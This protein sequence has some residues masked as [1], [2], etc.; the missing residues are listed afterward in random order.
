MNTAAQLDHTFAALADPTR[1]AILARLALGEATVNELARPF[2][3]SQPAIS[4][5]LKVLEAAGLIEAGQDAQRRPRRLVARPLAEVSEWLEP[6]R[7]SWEESFARLDSL[8]EEM[9]G[10]TADPLRQAQGGLSASLG[11]GRD[12]SKKGSPGRKGAAKRGE[13]TP[14]P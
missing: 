2:A 13:G 4:R 3:I 6:Y 8:L 11:S 7:K 14:P 9:Q 10:S 5:H 12:D 1:R